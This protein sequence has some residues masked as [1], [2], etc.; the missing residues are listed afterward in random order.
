ME[1]LEHMISIAGKDH[2]GLGFDFNFYFGSKGIDGLNDCTY[3]PKRT[4]EMVKRG[5]SST[6]INKILGENFVRILKE[7][8][9]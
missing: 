6:T 7:I 2:V 1:Q 3:V 5:Y 4:E 8:L 9:P